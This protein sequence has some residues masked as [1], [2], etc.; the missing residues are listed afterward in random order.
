MDGTMSPNQ[1]TVDSPHRFLRRA[2]I[3]Q[4]AVGYN[5]DGIG[6]WISHPKV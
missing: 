2:T 5:G 4:A 1:T 6:Q 3:S